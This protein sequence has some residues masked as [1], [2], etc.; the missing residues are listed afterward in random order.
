MIPEPRHRTSDCSFEFLNVVPSFLL[1]SFRKRCTTMADE[2]PKPLTYVP[3]VILKKRK[4]NEEWAIRRK[5][6]LEQRVKKSKGD[7]FVI[8]KPEQ[9]IREYRDK[10][11]LLY[12]IQLLSAPRGCFCF[13]PFGC[14]SYA[15]SVH[16]TWVVAIVTLLMQRCTL[17]RLKELDLIQMKHRVKRPRRAIGTPESK[18][19]LIIRIQGKNDMHPKTRKVLYSLRLRRVFSGVFVKANERIMQILQKVE[20]YVTYG[21]PTLKNVSDLIYKKGLAKVDKQ[22]V[23]LTDNNMI[24]QALGQY[25]IICIEDIVNEVANVGKH[26]REVT[27]FLCPFALNKPEKALQ[28]KKKP[29]KNGGDAGNREDHINDL[30]D[31]MN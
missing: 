22:R 19:L 2:E 13:A 23:P 24:E 31:K 21:Y 26:F 3:E 1:F 30:I 11:I 4:N 20:P 14:L 9:F 27:S 15:L 18:L 29:Y 12:I 28:G 10:V 6:Q 5:L 7:N 8:K 25:G 16:G 17:S